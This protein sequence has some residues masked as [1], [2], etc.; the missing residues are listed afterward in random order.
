MMAAN[1]DAKRATERL[2]DAGELEAIAR[3]CR[4]LPTRPDVVVGPGDDCA[5][6]RSA[7]DA[8]WDWLLK[9]DPVVEGVHFLPDTPP[10][11]IGHKA[12]G[13]VLSDL[14][15]MGGEP[16][17]GLIDVTA[18]PATPVA[19][20]EGIYAG[21]ARLAARHGLA[22]VGG[23][24]ARAEAL[25]LHVFAVGRAPRGQA[26]LRRGAAPGDL[27][28][29]TGALGG[30]L[31][32]RHLAFEPR[33]AAGQRL[34][35]WATA[36]LD[37]SDGLATDLRRLCDA[38]GVGAELDAAAIPLAPAALDHPDGRPALEHALSDGEDFE[39]LFALRPDR[40]GA[41]MAQ[42]TAGGELPA[43]TCIGRATAAAGAV[44]IRGQDGRLAPLSG[45]GYEHFQH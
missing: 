25:H 43:C 33:L 42:W 45:H 34:R 10:E 30:S 23:D 26:V 12:V 17:W 44:H 15:A 40:A 28:F 8:A 9:S 13:R 11:A 19:R 2:G 16:C 41:F 39:L 3:L 27:L 7:T 18:P 36:M 38:S 1:D 22:I 24:L 29:V 37:L 6:V 20:L 5:V 4:H 32:G 31:L 21:A 14:A 35:G